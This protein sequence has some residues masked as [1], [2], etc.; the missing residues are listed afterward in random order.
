[1]N[2]TLAPKNELGI[3]VAYMIGLTEL[4]IILLILLLYPIIGFVVLNLLIKHGWIKCPN[5]G[6]CNKP[7][8]ESDDH[9]F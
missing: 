7:E 5:C 2:K 8:S 6:S 4:I 1:M 3:E 9:A